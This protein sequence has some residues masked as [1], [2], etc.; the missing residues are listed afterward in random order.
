M[1]NTEKEARRRIVL[2]GPPGA[3]KGT[4][5][6]DL[7]LK[8]KIPHI[9]TGDILREAVKLGTPV[10]LQA[11]SYMDKGELVPDQVMAQV[12]LERLGH[13]D[14]EGGFLLDGYPRTLPQAKLLEEG[15]EKQSRGLD[16]AIDVGCPE[17]LIISR[18]AHRRICKKCGATYHLKNIPP[19]VSGACD[20]CAGELYQR[21]D[22][23]EET[24]RRR[25]EVYRHQSEPLVRYY[26]SKGILEKVDGSLARNET[27]QDLMEI[28]GHHD[29]H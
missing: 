16:I 6:R 24:V 9:S 1:K 15:F 22:D 18:L 12:I 17:E 2:L 11:K 8:L 19:K 14:C 23:R 3:G 20:V 5:A 25:L 28:V 7:A 29:H 10:G 27:L 21:E 26:E 13:M 4:Q